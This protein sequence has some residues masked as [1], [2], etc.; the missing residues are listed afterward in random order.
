MNFDFN[1]AQSISVVYGLPICDRESNI[2]FISLKSALNF[3][4]EL[5]IYL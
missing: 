3:G 1:S 5:I 4:I 2:F